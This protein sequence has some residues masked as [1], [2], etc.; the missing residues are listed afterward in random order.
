MLGV[1]CHFIIPV[2]QAPTRLV[3]LM[4]SRVFCYESLPPATHVEVLPEP[5]SCCKHVSHTTLVTATGSN[6]AYSFDTDG[7]SFIIDNSETC[8]M[9]NKRDLFVGCLKPVQV[10]M[11]TC[12]GDITKQRYL[13]TL[14]LVLTDDSN[15]KPLIRHSRLYL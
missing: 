9:S 14:R 3:H 11:T 1:A 12:E 7:V 8:I 2:L 13:G 4:L 10:S 5:C 6:D 15:K